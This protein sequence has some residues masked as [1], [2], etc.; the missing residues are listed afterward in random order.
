MSLSVRLVPM[1][2]EQFRA[3]RDVAEHAYADNIAQAGMMPEPESREKATA[4]FDQIL[5]EGLDTT[6]QMF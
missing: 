4:D 5:P 3:Y 1:S 2:P 6:D